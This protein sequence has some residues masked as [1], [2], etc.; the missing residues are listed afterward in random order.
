[1]RCVKFA[2]LK[3]NWIINKMKTIL[4][5]VCGWCGKDMGQKDGQGQTGISHGMCPA[6]YKKLTGKEYEGKC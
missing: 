6:C 4:Y 3:L 1:M 2:I 5:V